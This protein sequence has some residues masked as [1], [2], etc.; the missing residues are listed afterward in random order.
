[1]FKKYNKIKKVFQEEIK[2]THGKASVT[3]YL[4]LRILIII[5]MILEFLRGD[6]NNAFLC[7]LSLVLFLMPFFIEKK[8]KIDLPDTLE[9]IIFIFIFSAEILGEINN[10]Y[11]NIPHWDTILHT[12]NGFLCASVGF[13]LVYLL[14]KE[15]DSVNLSPI[16]ITLV[17]FCFSMTIGIAWEFFEYASDTVL[18]IDMQKDRYIENINT[19]LTDETK[20]NKTIKYNDIEY[21]ILYDEQ[22]NEIAKINNYIDIGLHDTMK[23]LLVNFIGALVFSIFGYLYILNKEKYNFIDN[24]LLKKLKQTS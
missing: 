11:G 8:F 5:C 14:N 22:G 7:L 2:Q 18:G 21:T 1:M 20:S 15:V 24:F 6:L 13:S 4:T 19:V 17:A 23:D 9:I 3:V 12:I 10:F 16:F